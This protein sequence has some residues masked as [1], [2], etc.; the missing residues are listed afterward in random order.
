MKEETHWSM[1]LGL[2]KTGDVLARSD[3]CHL[4]D[5]ARGGGVLRDRPEAAAAGSGR[6]ARGAVRVEPARVGGPPVAVGDHQ[7]PSAPEV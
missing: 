3:L 1:V 5:G 7:R 6:R 4:H 2:K